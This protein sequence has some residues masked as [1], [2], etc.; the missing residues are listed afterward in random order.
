MRSLIVSLFCIYVYA[1]H[2][3]VVDSIKYQYGYLYYRT[4]GRGEP[5]IMLSGGPGNNALQLESVA[6]KISLNYKAIMLEQRGTGL[7][8]VSPMDSTTI[9]MEAAISDVDLLLT[10]LGLKKAI[11]FG[12]SYGGSLALVYAC[13]YPEKIKSLVLLAPG[14]F[15][16][17]KKSYD[18]TYDKII[19]SF[20]AGELTRITELEKKQQAGKIT[21]VELL[22]MRKLNRL[23]YIYDKS[24]IDSLY[25]L[26]DGKNNRVTFQLMLNSFLKSN[27]DLSKE[28][29]K[30]KSPI[31][32][33]C[34]R[35][36][37]LT[38][39]AYDLKIA[40]PSINLCW[41]E[42]SGHFPM[43]ERAEEFYKIMFEVLA[44]S[45]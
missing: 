43:H 36:D 19:G 6:K 30:I 32:L 38:Y 45:R 5:V 3:Q 13:R 44:K 16:L 4:Y 1:A 24:K 20:S 9:N 21:E 15:G 25:P 10:H 37:F 17:G 42:R 29:E 18:V 26:M 31:H 27:Y 28:M 7:S 23:P 2:G 12:H 11:I 41:I 35:E 34:G 33:I 22:E 14:Y 39:V 8:V 40:K